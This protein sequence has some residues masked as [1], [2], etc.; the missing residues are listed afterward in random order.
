MTTEL[1]EFNGVV[2]GTLCRGENTL[3]QKEK[4][5]Q[6]K[7]K[8][9]TVLGGPRIRLEEVGQY[10]FIHDTIAY[11][12]LECSVPVLREVIQTKDKPI[13][14]IL[15]YAHI[16]MYQRWYIFCAYKKIKLYR[17]RLEAEKAIV[18]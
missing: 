17:S 13:L 14:T 1:D 5:Q 2:S 18:K 12:A 4:R 3:T 9:E 10:W 15:E 8:Y 7:R 6:Y 11:N 16:D